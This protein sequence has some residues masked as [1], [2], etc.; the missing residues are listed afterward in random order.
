[1][2]VDCGVICPTAQTKQRIL[3]FRSIL[4]RAAAIGRRVEGERGGGNGEITEQ[5]RRI[6][7]MT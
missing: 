2:K 7:F 3:P 1:V 5:M 4:I 6:V